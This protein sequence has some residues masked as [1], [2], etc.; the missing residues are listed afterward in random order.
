MQIT[1]LSNDE[2]QR[3]ASLQQLNLLG[4]PPEH[5][6]DQITRLVKRHFNVEIVLICL[7][8]SDRIWFKSKQGLTAEETFREGSFCSYTLLNDVCF[9]VPD[10]S[11]DPRF[12]DSPLVTGDLAVRFYAGHPLTMRNGQRVGTLCLM[13]SSPRAFSPDDEIDLHTFADM[14]EIEMQTQQLQEDVAQARE[15]EQ[16]ASLVAA[17]LEQ[18]S[19]VAKHTSNAVI[20][21]DRDG[22]V[23]WV[24]EG[25]TR[26]SGYSL[27]EVIG[28]RP[29]HI[30]QGTASDTNVVRQMSEAIKSGSGFNT[31]IINYH[32]NGTA[33]WI[34][35]SI[36]P[37][38]DEQGKLSQFIA[39]E[40]DISFQKKLELEL[41]EAN[42]LMASA[43]RIAGVGVWQFDLVSNAIFWSEQTRK[44]H[45]VSIDFIP[46]FE[47]AIN[48]YPQEVHEE[49]SNHVQKAIETRTPWEFELPLLTAKNRSIWV[50]SIG[51]TVVENDQVVKLIGTFQDVTQRR[52][53]EK[54][55]LEFISTVSHELR[56][57]LTSIR[58]SLS[59][60]A[61]N[62]F[63]EL[64]EKMQKLVDVAHRNSI[65]LVELVNDILDMNKLAAGALKIDSKDQDLIPVIHQAMEAT[66]AYAIQYKVRVK[67]DTTLSHAWVKVDQGRMIQVLVNLISNAC[68]FSKVDGVVE[69]KLF[70]LNSCYIL[71]VVDH[72]IGIAH[73]FFP[74]IFAQFA[75]ADGSNTRPQG[76]TGLGLNISKT[77]VEKMH[78]DIGF[79]SIEGEGSTFWISLPE[80]IMRT[81]DEAVPV[82]LE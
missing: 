9:H 2:S 67:L 57:P 44:I 55:Q 53:I 64:P 69:L 79:R 63:G 30:L 66:Q 47:S 6:F 39:I 42:A 26:I 37:V 54:V 29:G 8:D 56:T 60:L 27:A 50:K 15:S 76:G 23:T 13:H 61:S 62:V 82:H 59:L 75:Q 18:L 68:K 38:Y 14:V 19:L 41:H 34:S 74:R 78:G 7:V 10:A 35:L 33:Y 65:R 46:T 52:M 36:E 80:Q 12:I 45:E 71:E 22:I 17:E 28:H 25:F 16:Q 3:L 5:R 77:L 20:I 24:N 48:F 4:T 31:E 40:S 11:Q 51:E 32:K 43:A 49:L 73:D 81:Y 58:G 72:G 70:T 21:T 1:S